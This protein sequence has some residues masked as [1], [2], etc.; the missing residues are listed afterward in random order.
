MVVTRSKI[1]STSTMENF[2]S[3]YLVTLEDP[4]IIQRFHLIFE[5]MFKKLVDPIT[6]KLQDTIDS[7]ARSI[8]LMKKE[9]AEDTKM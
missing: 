9:S 6:H 5:P 2:K 4:G 3:N 7:M 1:S 8:S